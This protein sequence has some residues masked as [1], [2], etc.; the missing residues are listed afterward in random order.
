MIYLDG[1]LIAERIKK[2]LKEQSVS[3]SHPLRLAIVSVGT[4]PVSE[5]FITLKEKFAHEIG[6]ETRRYE[7][8][9]TITT[10][11]LRNSMNDIVHEAH[12]DGVIVQLPLPSHIDTQGV[13]NAIVPEKDVDVLSARA[14]GNVQ[15]GKSRIL[16]PVAGAVKILFEEYSVSVKGAAAVVLGYGRLVGQPVATWLISVGAQVTIVRDKAELNPAVTSSADIIIAGMGN[17]RG[18]TGE[19]VKSGAAV[20]DVGTSESEGVIAGDVDID[21]VVEKAAFLTP[22]RGGVGPLTVAFV[23]K[24]LFTLVEGGRRG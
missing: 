22:L 5:K 16:A 13:L 4:N 23:F 7:F 6:V 14:V 17:P 10:N 11:E 15:V 2:E 18:V 19:Y 1:R 3:R 24:N 9:E 21:S 8:P 12:N 20:I